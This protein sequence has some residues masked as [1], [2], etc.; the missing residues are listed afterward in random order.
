M[1]GYDSENPDAIP[2]DAPV[3]NYYADGLAG[4]LTPTGLARFT[5]PYKFSITRVATVGAYWADIEPGCIWPMQTGVDMLTAGLVT[6]LYI[7]ESNWSA[8]RDLIAP[9]A[10]A[11]PYWVAEYPDTY[12]TDPVIPQSWL[13]ENCVQWQFSSS[14]GTSPGDYDLSVTAPTWPESPPR[15]LVTPAI[16]RNRD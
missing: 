5:T 4:S 12:P 1:I 10:F 15:L 16:W 7:D 11:P 2:S 14:P 8:L 13:D 9:T 6:G 3:L